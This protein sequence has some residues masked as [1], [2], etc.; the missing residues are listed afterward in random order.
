MPRPASPPFLRTDDVFK[1]LHL[2]TV[3]DLAKWKYVAWAESLVALAEQ[4]SEDGSS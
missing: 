3:A 1:K 2:H 4:E